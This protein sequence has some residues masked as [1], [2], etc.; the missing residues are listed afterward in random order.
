M[1]LVSSSKP[2]VPIREEGASRLLLAVL[3]GNGIPQPLH[4]LSDGRTF[5]VIRPGGT[6]RSMLIDM[7]NHGSQTE[8]VFFDLPGAPRTDDEVPYSDQ[9]RDAPGAMSHVIELT[10]ADPAI[11]TSVQPLDFRQE[12]GSLYCI[13]WY[14]ILPYAEE[15]MFFGDQFRRGTRLGDL[16]I[17]YGPKLPR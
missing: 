16:V 15:Y 11:G 17:H 10:G 13:A 2:V 12:A 7:Q 1:I 9:Y 3:D 14:G 6:Y 8:L 4:R 5:L